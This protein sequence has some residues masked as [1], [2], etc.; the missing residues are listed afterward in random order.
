MHGT[1]TNALLVGALPRILYSLP[2]PGCQMADLLGPHPAH[3][4][5]K[6]C[7]YSVLCNF[8]NL[9]HVLILLVEPWD[10]A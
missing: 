5:L 1:A 8:I 10:V 3:L 9:N 4:A 7:V 2:I 6:V